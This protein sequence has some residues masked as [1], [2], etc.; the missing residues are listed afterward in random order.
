MLPYR[1]ALLFI[2][3]SYLLL[4]SSCTTPM[5]VLMFGRPSINDA[6]IFNCDTVEVPPKPFQ[7]IESPSYKP[8]PPIDYW[9][10]KS[11]NIDDYETPEEFFKT[12]ETSSFLVIRNDSI[13]YENYFNGYSRD[14]PVIIFSLSKAITTALVGIAIEEG[15]FKNTKQRVAEFIPAFA[16]DERRDITIEN[17]MQMTSGL[18]VSDHKDF[19]KI[20][21]LY[22]NNQLEEYIKKTKL[23]YKPGT[24]FAYK[25]L[26]TQI[27]SLCLE[28]AT[29]RRLSDYLQEKIWQPL[30]MECNALVTLD[31]QHG[32]ARSY[33]GIAVCARDL[34]KIGRLYLNNGN[35]NGKQVIPTK[36]ITKSTAISDTS[37]WWGYATGW[38]L[39]TYVNQNLYEKQDFVAK[40]FSGQRIYVDPESNVIIIRQGNS[41]RNVNWTSLCAR[42]NSL[43]N[44]CT[45]RSCD[46]TEIDKDLFEGF[47]KAKGGFKFSIVRKNSAKWVVRSGLF[48]T[49][50]REESPQC[51]FNNRRQHRYIFE[52]D[53]SRQNVVGLYWDNLQKMTYCE[54]VGELKR[55]M[56]KNKK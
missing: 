42:L 47:Y 2:F 49:T 31:R 29:G 20:A 33:G 44:Y 13:L 50:I 7:F 52:T 9:I 21:A 45:P 15:Y 25:S 36:W 18:N 32:N 16:S 8:L 17:L 37:H 5:R 10:K 12:T 38:W 4:N 53:H 28:K 51:L 35:W 24:H 54:K 11:S 39:N 30:G 22:Y 40:G 34:A 55:N 27:L 41:Q 19:F 46:I 1:I 3:Y 26:D 48:R 14:Q 43:L 6:A 23:K 56:K